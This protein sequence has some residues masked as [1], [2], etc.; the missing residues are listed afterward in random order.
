MLASI[1][2]LLSEPRPRNFPIVRALVGDSTITSEV[3]PELAV[4]LGM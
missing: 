2:Y 3:P 1:T 4:F